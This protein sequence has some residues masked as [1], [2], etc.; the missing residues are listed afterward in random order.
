MTVYVKTKLLLLHFAHH[1][2]WRCLCVCVQLT[3]LVEEEEEGGGTPA[4]AGTED[5]ESVSDMPV[6]TDT[7]SKL[8]S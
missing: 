4:S 5:V 7:H 8:P 6:R 3:T 2:C 1:N